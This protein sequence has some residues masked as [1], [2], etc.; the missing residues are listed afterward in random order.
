MGSDLAPAGNQAVAGPVVMGTDPSKE[1][2]PMR[3]IRPAAVLAVALPLTLLSVSSASA[4]GSWFMPP[5]D[6][7]VVG[8]PAGAR[9]PFGSGQLEG[10][11]SDGPFTVYLVPANRAIP[12]DG[13]STPPWAIPLGELRITEGSNY[14]MVASISFTVPDVPAGSYRLDYCNVPC[15]V[16]GIGDLATAGSFAI[17][18]T[19]TEAHLGAAVDRLELKVESL[20]RHTRKVPQLRAELEDADRQAAAL[21]TR[22]EGLAAAAE[23]LRTRIGDLRSQLRVASAGSGGSPT[24]LTIALMLAL[25]LV[26]IAL[27]VTLNRSKTSGREPAP[28]SDGDRLNAAGARPRSDDVPDP[29]AKAPEDSLLTGPSWK[30]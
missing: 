18:S 13:G 9:T 12:S 19:L 15:T 25:L 30:G 1:V 5:G 29:G 26:T 27:I 17:G 22:N 11:V 21:E 10:K 20:E 23:D 16:D 6:A 24:G 4:G 14:G 28:M 7:Y 8:D 3:C 2:P